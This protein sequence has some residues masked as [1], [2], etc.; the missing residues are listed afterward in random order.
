MG[1]PAHDVL[2]GVA[3][4]MGGMAEALRSL[5]EGMRV[6]PSVAHPPPRSL[7][8]IAE[9]I[10]AQRKGRTRFLPPSLFHEPAWEVLLSLYVA[11]CRGR[12]VNIKHLTQAVDAPVTTA[13]RWVDA[14]AHMRL[15]HRAVD[16]FDRRRV[17]LSLTQGAMQAVEGYLAW[18]VAGDHEE[19]APA[20][21]HNGSG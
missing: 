20:L 1:R 12:T 21:A 19:R 4:Q 18:L 14:L 7:V 9:R 11:Q 13:Q 2:V 16:D 3:D 5:A 15:V 10:L 8:E 6:T 17:E